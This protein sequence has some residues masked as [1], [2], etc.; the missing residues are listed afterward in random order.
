MKVQS[1]GKEANHKQDAFA[2]R[3]SPLPTILLTLNALLI[4]ACI[5]LLII[6]R[7]LQ[8]QLD[9]YVAA[10]SMA[11]ASTI[12]DLMDDLL[13]VYM[14]C[15]SVLLLLLLLTLTIWA[16]TRTQSS[17]LRYGSLLLMFLAI[18][19]VAA[20]WLLGISGVSDPLPAILPQTPTP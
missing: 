19:A 3:R 5:T 9:V 7:L 18:S 8:N 11:A 13:L 12:L 15:G 17:L 14:F 20:V 1:S 16:W 4:G 6:S 2:R 10:E